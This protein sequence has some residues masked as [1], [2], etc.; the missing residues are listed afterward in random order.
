L[1]CRATTSRPASRARG[2][3][4]GGIR[5]RRAGHQEGL[6]NSL[7]DQRNLARADAFVV[8]AVPA[9]QI[10][11][12]RAVQRR[13]E[14]HAEKFGQHAF[15]DALGEGLAVGFVLLPV[16]FDAVAENFVEENAGRASAENGRADVGLDERGLQEIDEIL[17]GPVDGGLDLAILGERLRIGGREE[18]RRGQIHSIL[19]L[20]LGADND[21]GE[22]P[23]MLKPRSFGGDEILG[24]AQ[25]RDAEAGGEHVGIL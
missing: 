17:G 24:F 21:A 23:A 18:V 11:A 25:R 6:E 22:R 5:D 9:V 3:S 7:F 15:A 12:G 14:R 16:A 13:V 20:A 4:S 19:G 2:R 10:L 8:E 1:D